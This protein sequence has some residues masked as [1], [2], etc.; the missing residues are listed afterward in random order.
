MWS[1]LSKIAEVCVK[2]I[3]YIYLLSL[4]SI[5]FVHETSAKDGFSPGPWETDEGREKTGS[6]TDNQDEIE[7]FTPENSQSEFEE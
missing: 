6:P 3:L 7:H 1:V 2:K 4:V 5:F